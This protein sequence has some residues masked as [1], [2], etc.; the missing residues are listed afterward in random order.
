MAHKCRT[1][2]LSLVLVDHDES[3]LGLAGLN[4]HVTSAANHWPLAFVQHGDQGD[5]VDKVDVQEERDF[6][7]RKAPFRRE[8]AAVERLALVRLTSATSLSRSSGLRERISIRRPL[9]SNSMTEYLAV[10]N[11]AGKF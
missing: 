6:F 11:M 3:Y 4:D 2:P 1:D 8:E 9:R 5:V 10:S 7:L